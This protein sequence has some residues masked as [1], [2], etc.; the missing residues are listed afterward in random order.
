[1][2]SANFVLDAGAFKGAATALCATTAPVGL[3]VT[4]KG[5]GAVVFGA[6][7]GFTFIAPALAGILTYGMI[8][9]LIRRRHRSAASDCRSCGGCPTVDQPGEPA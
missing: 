5:L 3:A 9:T 8:S 7:M 1:M 6:G 2:N 4:G